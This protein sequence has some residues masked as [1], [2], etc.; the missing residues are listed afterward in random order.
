M[1]FSMSIQAQKRNNCGV[2]IADGL[3]IKDRMLFNRA[4]SHPADHQS[5]SRSGSVLYVPVQ[6]TIV[7]LTDNTGYVDI[8]KVFDMFCDLNEDYGAF[9]VQF[10]LKDQVNSIRYA[11]NNAVY[12]DAFSSS[13]ATF[14]E[15][16]KVPNCLNMY[17]SPSELFPS[18]SFYSPN[19][20]YLFMLEQMTN[21]SEN[22]GTHEVGHFFSLPHTF[23]G[24]EGIDFNLQTAP[25]EVNGT[26]VENVVRTGPDANCLF[27]GDG[28]C[29]TEADY[30]SYREDCPYPAGGFDPLGVSINPDELNYMSYSTC[31]ANFSDD[32]EAAVISDIEARNWDNFNLPS[33]SGPVSGEAITSV[34]PTSGSIFPYG[35]ELTMSWNSVPGATGYVV[36]LSSLSP[37]TTV[38]K[39]P[40]YDT[41]LVIPLSSLEPGTNYRWRIRPFNQSNTC[42]NY[43]T[44]FNFELDGFAGVESGQTVNFEF[45]VLSNP[46]A[47]NALQLTL[48]TKQP[49]DGDIKIFSVDGKQ[50]LNL[51]SLHFEEGQNDRSCD[52]SLLANGIYILELTST[53]GDVLRKKVVLDR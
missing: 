14:M 30:I 19:G 21:G 26:L 11:N 37:F 3:R 23:S 13:A 22:T 51:K 12:N 38:V 40:I 39:E 42:G 31:T 6:F 29:G 47:N 32:Q 33:P 25:V 46:I 9:G 7:G 5:G 43:S 34:I 48:H 53:L 41:T 4:H 50:Q 16:N 49:M 52:V 20:D 35:T 45:N 18:A 8:D 17:F 15:N 10:Y 44:W 24:W 1:I 27:A 2:G 28:F 36:W